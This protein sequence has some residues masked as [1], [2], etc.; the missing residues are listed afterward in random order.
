MIPATA[1][2]IRTTM[3]KYIQDIAVLIS[4]GLEGAVMLEMYY[5][6]VFDSVVKES[7]IV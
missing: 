2:R 1:A 4:G 6:T 3:R 7:I 5:I